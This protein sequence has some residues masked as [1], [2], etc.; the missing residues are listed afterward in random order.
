MFVVMAVWEV[1]GKALNT[2]VNAVVDYL[3]L[4]VDTKIACETRTLATGQF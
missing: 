1:W 2:T 4:H 3:F